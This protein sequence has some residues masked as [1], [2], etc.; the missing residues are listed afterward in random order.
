MSLYSTHIHCWHTK[1]VAHITISECCRCGQEREKRGREY[2][3]PYKPWCYR[4]T[5]RFYTRSSESKTR[6]NYV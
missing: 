5:P 6:F 1:N 4:E 2:G 3:D